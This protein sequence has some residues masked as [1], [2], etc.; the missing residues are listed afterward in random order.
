MYNLYRINL[1]ALHQT[2][3]TDLDID[4]N[5]TPATPHI[6]SWFNPTSDSI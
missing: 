3:G 2:K 4:Q 5:S 1:S 6:G